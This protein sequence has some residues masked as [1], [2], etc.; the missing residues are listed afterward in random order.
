MG[1]LDSAY[2]QVA[3]QL[4]LNSRALG[5][6]TLIMDAIEHRLESLFQQMAATAKAVSRLVVPKRHRFSRFMT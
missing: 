5:D 1:L 4:D 6:H 3:I 2:Q